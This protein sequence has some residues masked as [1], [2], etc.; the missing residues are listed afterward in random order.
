MACNRPGPSS[1]EAERTRPASPI[2]HGGPDDHHEP[3]SH[4]PRPPR[5]REVHDPMNHWYINERVAA[6]HRAERMELAGRHRLAKQARA[7]RKPAPRAVPG[8][9]KMFSA[10]HQQRWSGVV[11]TDPAQAYLSAW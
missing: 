5:R 4:P 8:P 11:V 6:E 1:T 10:W 2:G 9:V 7:H 3:T